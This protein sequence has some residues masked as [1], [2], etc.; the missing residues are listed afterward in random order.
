MS[1]VMTPMLR[2][3]ASSRQISAISDDFPVPTGPATPSRRVCRSG[4]MA[5]EL[6]L[7][8]TTWVSGTEQPLARGGM[9]LGPLLDLRRAERGQLPGVRQP[10]QV[11]DHTLD[12]RPGG[13]HPTGRDHRVEWFELEGGGGHG[14]RVVVPDQ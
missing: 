6:L 3:A 8:V 11:D 13:D 14:L 7:A 1:L 5:A 9:D 4:S 2:S 12:L 10:R